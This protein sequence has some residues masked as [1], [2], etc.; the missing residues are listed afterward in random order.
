MSRTT[1][2]HAT[3]AHVQFALGELMGIRRYSS[4]HSERPGHEPTVEVRFKNLRLDMSEHTLRELV[5][6]G[7]EVLASPR[8]NFA[9][10]ADV[11]GSAAN[12]EGETA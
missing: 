5:R 8:P 11:S 6:R 3:A 2:A 12:I 9:V 7:Q 10:S 1:L 4:W